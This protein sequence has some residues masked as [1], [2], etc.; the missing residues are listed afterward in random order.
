MLPVAPIA[1]MHKSVPPS[2]TC[3]GMVVFLSK[4]NHSYRNQGDQRNKNVRTEGEQHQPPHKRELI[5]VSVPSVPSIEKR[6][7]TKLPKTEKA[8]LISERGLYL[9]LATCGVCAASEPRA[10]VLSERSESKDLLRR[11]AGVSEAGSPQ[12][13]S[14]SVSVRGISDCLYYCQ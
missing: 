11:F 10:A 8:T 2:A 7:M 14:R 3:V 5:I 9:M 1:R 4:L 13:K 12:P 6:K